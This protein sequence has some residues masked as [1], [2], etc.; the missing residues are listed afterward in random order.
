MNYRSKSKFLAISVIPY[1]KFQLLH[2]DI[3][4]ENKYRRTMSE[5]FL[6]TVSKRASVEIKTL[7]HTFLEKYEQEMSDA[8]CL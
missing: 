2:I 1:L 5:S 7:N 3:A 8:L 4:K 6:I